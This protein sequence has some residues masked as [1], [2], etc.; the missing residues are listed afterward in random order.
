[1]AIKISNTTVID[2]SRNGSMATMTTTGF[3]NDSASAISAAGTTQGTATAITT[4]IVDV[5]TV[6]AGTGVILPD[7]VTGRRIVIR[8]SGVNDLK[9]YPGVGDQINSLGTNVAFTEGTLTT[10][11]FVGFNTNQWYTLNSTFA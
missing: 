3:V 1:M 4:N 2:D 11:E 7:P 8:N 9:I 10:L 5:T 6:A